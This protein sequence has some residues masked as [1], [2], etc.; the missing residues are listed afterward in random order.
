MKFFNFNL[1][2]HR[3][4][5]YQSKEWREIRSYILSTHPLCTHCLK[6]DILTPAEEIDHIIPLH[7]DPSKRLDL[8]NLQPLC[9]KCHSTKTYKETLAPLSEKPKL[10]NPLW[11]L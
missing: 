1:P 8:T 5:F 10:A 2:K 6:E 9:K 11:N 4:Q 7:I 3:N